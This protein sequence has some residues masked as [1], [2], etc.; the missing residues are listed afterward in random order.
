MN[1]RPIGSNESAVENPPPYYDCHID[2]YG[3]LTPGKPPEYYAQIT[4]MSVDINGYEGT[5]YE[6]GAIDAEYPDPND[7]R[8]EFEAI[9]ADLEVVEQSELSDPSAYSKVEN[10][11]APTFHSEEGDALRQEEFTLSDAAQESRRTPDTEQ[12][13]VLPARS[14]EVIT[15]GNHTAQEG[16]PTYDPMHA[17]A[18]Y[19][20]EAYSRSA[21]KDMAPDLRQKYQMMAAAAIGAFNDTKFAQGER[22]E[23]YKQIMADQAVSIVAET[24]AKYAKATRPQTTRQESLQA[25]ADLALEWYEPYVM[26]RQPV[27]AKAIDQPLEWYESYTAGQ[28]A[29]ITSNISA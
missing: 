10:H 29:K 26:E 25:S 9:V 6:T 14:V 17:L 16:Q 3:M 11:D 8:R 18:A 12:L 27:G 4:N 22:L 1:I 19:A 5:Y 23:E 13:P 24:E 15:E 7:P 2:K 21:A 20:F 28:Q